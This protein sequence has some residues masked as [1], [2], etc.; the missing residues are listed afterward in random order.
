MTCFVKWSILERL[1]PNLIQW[2]IGSYRCHKTCGT[3]FFKRSQII[4]IDTFAGTEPYQLFRTA[5]D[6]PSSRQLEATVQKVSCWL[7]QRTPQQWLTYRHRVA[8][9]PDIMVILPQDLSSVDIPSGK[10]LEVSVHNDTD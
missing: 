8:Q 7:Y 9:C 2:C 1:T 3:I 10:P 5:S 4:L 6:S